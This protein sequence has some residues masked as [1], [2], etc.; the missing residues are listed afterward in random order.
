MSA[1]KANKGLVS[2]K[3]YRVTLALPVGAVMNCGDNTGAKNLY[4]IAVGNCGAR[5]NRLPAA[6]VG[7]YMLCSVKK[8]K[9]EL[10]K[11]G[12]SPSFVAFELS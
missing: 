8:G 10:R 12:E 7:D 6:S 3:K 9:P 1:K 5:L 2:G 11:K 4:V